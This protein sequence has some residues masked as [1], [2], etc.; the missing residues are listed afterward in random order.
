MPSQGQ[1]RKTGQRGTARQS[2]RCD[3]DMWAEFR[4]AAEVE[5]SNASAVLVAFI[6]WYLSR[7]K[8]RA[9]RRPKVEAE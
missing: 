4:E 7:P 5:G 9:P 3:P 8:S 1:E 2:F 6:K